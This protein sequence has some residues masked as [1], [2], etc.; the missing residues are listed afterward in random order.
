MNGVALGLVLLAGHFM[1]GGWEGWRSLWRKGLDPKLWVAAGAALITLGLLQPFLIADPGRILRADSTDDFLYALK[2][3]RGE[4]LHPWS[5]ADVHTLPYLHYWTDL[6]PLG[7]GWPL[8]VFSVFGLV[9]ALWKRQ[10]IEA[11]MAGWCIFYFLQIGG[12]HNKHLRYLLP[13]LPFL[14][15]FAAD[16]CAAVWRRNRYIGG[17]V[18]GGLVVYT[19]F[20]GLAFVQIYR[21]ED[22]RTQ[23][24]RWIA[25]ELPTGAHIGVER[26]GFSMRGMISEERFVKES[27]DVTALFGTSRYLSCRAGAEY[28]RE[29]MQGFDYIAVIDANRYRQ[30]VAAADLYP[31]LASFY[32]RLWAGKL[33]FRLVRRFKTYPSFAGVIFAD[34]DAEP[35]FLGFD[36]PAVM[37]FERADSESV[38]RAWERWL[39]EIG[40]EVSCIDSALERVA[41]HCRT[42]DWPRALQAARMALQ[43]HPEMKVIYYVL[44]QIYDRM[45]AAEN[46]KEA[47]RRY[48]SGFSEEHSAYLIPWASS[49]T[50][51]AAGMPSL[52]LGALIQGKE[53]IEPFPPEVYP[54]VMHSY[55]H[56]G[57][58]LHRRG[59]VMAASQAYRLATEIDP[60]SDTFVKVGEALDEYG[61]W[62]AAVL[63]YER[64]LEMDPENQS[65]RA[66]IGWDFYLLG[67][68]VRAADACETA[69]ARGR[70]SGAE[71]SLGLVYLAQGREALAEETFARAVAEFGRA[72]GENVGIVAALRTLVEQGENTETSRRILETHWPQP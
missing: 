71:F 58:Y 65:A 12:L 37:I 67:D 51:T 44:A 72:E 1:G 3:A 43:R 25:E 57:K 63:A 2:L 35:S 52:A 26:G 42:E 8:T 49:L 9:Y 15:L 64:A 19:S 24:A 40:Q 36:H 28:L 47:V 59:Q 46:E 55:I 23:A 39:G 68:L 7:A 27:M 38:D 30:F 48:A 21:T 41:E 60:R 17:V 18:A 20:Y 22:S 29:R 69:F 4:V 13:M 54:R 11:L 32:H 62:E 16:L 61:E 14:S 5:L 45:D 66:N 10:L 56:A 50:L 33:G 6:W 34:D 70:H 31:T 53:W